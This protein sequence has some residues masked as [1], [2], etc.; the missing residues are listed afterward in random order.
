MQKLLSSP[1]CPQRNKADEGYSLQSQVKLLQEYAEKKQMEV[2]QIH[3]IPES[4]RGQ[5]E[6]KLFNVMMHDLKNPKATVFAL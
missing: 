3:I 1:G 4:A 6:R 5:Q 2:V